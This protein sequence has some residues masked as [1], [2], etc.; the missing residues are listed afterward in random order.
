V[1]RRRRIEQPVVVAVDPEWRYRWLRRAPLMLPGG[2]RVQTAVA[3]IEL[4]GASLPKRLAELE[5]VLAE[6]GLLEGAER[7]MAR[8]RAARARREARSTERR[9]A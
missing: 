7:R 9:R 6:H 2:H 8:L 3:R 5:E 1:A 4:S